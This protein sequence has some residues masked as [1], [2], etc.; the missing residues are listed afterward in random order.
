MNKKRLYEVLTAAMLL[1]TVAVA[2]GAL[3]GPG[4]DWHLTY[5]PAAR[6]VLA[7][8]D[9][10]APEFRFLNPPWALIPFLP[11]ALLPEAVGRGVLFAATFAAF[12]A[13]AHRVSG[14]DARAVALVLLSPPVIHCAWNANVEWLVVL[15]FVAPPPLALVLLSIKPQVG[16]VYFAYIVWR[17]W[18]SGGWGQLMKTAAPVAALTLASFAIFGFW[19]AAWAATPDFDWNASLWPWGLLLG[20]PLSVGAFLREREEAAWAASPFLAPYLAGHSYA[21][22]FLSLARNA[23]LLALAVAGLWAYALLAVGG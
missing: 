13:V 14:G 17:E 22:A 3:L 19:P 15:G 23:G 7:G 6:A 16:A 10:Y 8:S 11:L 9:P 4:I 5:R 1:L 18:R 2:A 20:A 21:G 12:G